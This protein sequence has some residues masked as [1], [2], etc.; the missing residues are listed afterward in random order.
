[1]ENLGE[2]VGGAV[3][4]GGWHY[5]GRTEEAFTCK[6]REDFSR[7]AEENGEAQREV[8]WGVAR[9]GEEFAGYLEI[10]MAD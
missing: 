1:M 4:N 6:A 2:G 7:G 9:V 5:G 10:S 3:G 8:I